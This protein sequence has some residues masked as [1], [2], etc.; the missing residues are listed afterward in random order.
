MAKLPRVAVRIIKA[1]S[2][3]VSPTQIDKSENGTVGDWIEPDIDLRAFKQLVE[4]SP[5]LPQCITAYENNI[6]GFGIGIRYKED[7]GEETKDMIAEFEALQ[8]IVDQ[9]SLECDTKQVFQDAVR[10]RETFGIAY[11]E[12]MRDT[13]GHGNPVQIEFI[14]DTISMRKSKPLD[15]AVEYTYLYNGEPIVRTKRFRKYKQEIGG[16]TVYFREFGDPR[17]MDRRTGEYLGEGETL[18]LKYHANEILDFTIGTEP[19]GTVR[20]MGQMM[21]VDGSRRAE[22]LNNNYFR[23]GR[24]TPLAIAIEGGSLSDDSYNKLTEYMNGIKGENG[25]HSF[26]L[27]EMES[28]DG[29][30]DFDQ[31]EKPKIQFKDLANILQKDELFQEYIDNS[32]RR[33]QS[34]FQLPDLY[35]AYTTDYNRATAQTAMEVTE[36]QVFQPERQSLAWIINNKLLNGYG[37]KYVEV[38]FKAPDMSNPDDMARIL[39]ECRQAGGL[40][41]NKAKDVLYKAL[42][43]V[44]EDYEGE[45]GNIPIGVSI[46]TS[47]LTDSTTDPSGGDAVAKSAKSHDDEI[48]AVMREV[49]KMLKGKTSEKIAPGDKP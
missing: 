9:F 37:F 27:L 5:I 14:G 39:S 33:V 32:R 47:K 2:D 31:K 29:R 21:G 24:H 18:D 23:E 28:T 35:V 45:W 1:M 3:A 22:S 46:D 25:Q 15:P 7:F 44:S 12:I 16:K 26:L 6:C 41:P 42:G 40:T 30:T 48:V 36:K 49:K 20:W 4:E 8:K 11:A 13:C 34:A 38:Y 10:A 17:I 19:Y 43:E